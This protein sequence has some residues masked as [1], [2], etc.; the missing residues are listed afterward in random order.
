MQ[1]FK[2]LTFWNKFFVVLI[3]F[4][5]LAAVAVPPLT[6]IYNNYKIRKES[7]AIWDK[8]NEPYYRKCVRHENIRCA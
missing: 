2:K 3:V 1:L 8:R 5:A 7:A 6:E 4:S